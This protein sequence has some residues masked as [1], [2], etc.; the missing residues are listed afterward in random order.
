MAEAQAEHRLNSGGRLLFDDGM[1]DED[2]EAW[3]A[4]RRDRREREK[5]PPTIGDG[6]N[7]LPF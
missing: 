6:S 3:A 4:A 5:N 1:F 2:R 7:D